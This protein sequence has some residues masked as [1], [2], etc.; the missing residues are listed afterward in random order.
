MREIDEVILA[1]RPFVRLP[2]AE[3]LNHGIL[4]ARPGDI[5]GLP[6]GVNAA[7]LHTPQLGAD[8]SLESPFDDQ[9]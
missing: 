2:P 7:R 4:A 5:F 1:T 9:N 6:G 8:R 3:T